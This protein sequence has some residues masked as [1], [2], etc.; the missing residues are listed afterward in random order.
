LVPCPPERV[1]SQLPRLDVLE[2]DERVLDGGIDGLETG[3]RDSEG[4]FA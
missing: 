1:V 4:A 2:L 3:P